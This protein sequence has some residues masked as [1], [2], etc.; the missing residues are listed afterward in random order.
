MTTRWIGGGWVQEGLVGV[1]GLDGFT[2]GVVDLE[3]GGLAAVVGVFG[4]VF[5]LHD[6][7]GVYDVADGMAGRGEGSAVSPSRRSFSRA[8]TL[9]Q[10]KT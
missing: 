4:L 9:S 8:S 2:E 10:K 6:E 5:A 7:E 1:A 3:D